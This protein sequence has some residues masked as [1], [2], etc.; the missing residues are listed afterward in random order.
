VSF[1]EEQQD[2]CNDA[3]HEHAGGSF[4]RMPWWGR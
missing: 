1:Y 3:Y 2:D 4:R